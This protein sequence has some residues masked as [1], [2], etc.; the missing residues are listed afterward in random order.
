MAGRLKAR[1]RRKQAVNVY[2]VGCFF[3]P[4]QETTKAIGA[5]E[6]DKMLAEVRRSFEYLMTDAA[7]CDSAITDESTTELTFQL[8]E[9]RAEIASIKLLVFTNAA[10]ETKRNRLEADPIADI[11]VKCAVLDWSEYELLYSPALILL[12][13]IFKKWRALPFNVSRLRVPK[14]CPLICWH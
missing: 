6:I 4:D 13:L 1:C 12:L 11:A 9:V 5:Q 7:L 2:G 8:N 3:D 14:V 10:F